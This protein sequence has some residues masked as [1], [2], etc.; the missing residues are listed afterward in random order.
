M[1]TNYYAGQLVVLW[2][3]TLSVEY[4]PNNH[5]SEDSCA[6]ELPG[7]AVVPG[8][9]VLVLDAINLALVW[10]STV[11]ISQQPVG[12]VVAV[13]DAATFT[14]GVAGVTDGVT[15]EWTLDGNPVGSGTATLVYNTT[16]HDAEPG[17]SVS[18]CIMECERVVM[19]HTSNYVLQS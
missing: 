17:G 8:I 18:P 12:S 9:G 19:P 14:V 7:L 2:N 3:G 4:A 11:S 16:S 15:F 1:I 6:W 13:G 10:L 5:Y